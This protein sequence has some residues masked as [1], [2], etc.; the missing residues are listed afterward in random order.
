MPPTEN[1]PHGRPIEPP[2][3]NIRFR[4]NSYSCVETHSSGVSTAQASRSPHLQ[5]SSVGAKYSVAA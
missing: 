5:G 2:T 4:V 3:E 1:I